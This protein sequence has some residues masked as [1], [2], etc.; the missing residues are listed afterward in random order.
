ME[1][2]KDALAD[3]QVPD[4][5]V[6]YDPSIS[7]QKGVQGSI[8]G[9][10][11][12]IVTGILIAIV[13]KYLGSFVQVDANTEN[14]IAGAVSVGVAAGIVAAKKFVENWMKHRNV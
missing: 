1:E 8:D 3:V 9:T 2:Q 6:K 7:A 10:I 5:P 11:A 14:I 13:K 12:A 4:A